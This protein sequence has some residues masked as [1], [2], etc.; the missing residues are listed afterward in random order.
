MN[1]LTY[2]PLDT[3]I[4]VFVY[5]SL[6]KGYHNHNYHLDNSIHLGTAETLP[7]YT[8]FSLG[9]YPG[10]IKDGIHSIKGE[11]Y[12]VNEDQLENLDMLEGHPGY[13]KREVIET[14]EGKAW[15]Y[16]LP[17]DQYPDVVPI[18]DGNWTEECCYG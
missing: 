11:M 14:S 8:L 17:E 6:K 4:T 13:Y 3:K 10:V 7:Q 12:E 5:G 16:L 2:E 15:I 9:S 18:E 1:K